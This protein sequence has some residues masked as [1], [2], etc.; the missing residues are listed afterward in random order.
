MNSMMFISGP[1]YAQQVGLAMALDACAAGWSNDGGVH[2]AGGQHHPISRL[3]LE[4]LAL[5]FEHERDRAFDAVKHLLE[6]V[7]VGRVTVAGAVRPRVAS[8]RLG[9]QFIHEV[10]RPHHNPIL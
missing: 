7:G 2:R 4:T 5:L 8:A 10:L 3:Q 6:A 9:S 1:Y